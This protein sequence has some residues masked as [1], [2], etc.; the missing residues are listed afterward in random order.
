M[1]GTTTTAAIHAD[2]TSQGSFRSTTFCFLKDFLNLMNENAINCG[3]TNQPL[4]ILDMIVDYMDN[5]TLLALTVTCHRFY[6][7][8]K[9]NHL[10]FRFMRCDIHRIHL[11]K[12]L[13]DLPLY[14][15]RIR[16]IELMPEAEDPLLGIDSVVE[17]IEIDAD[18]EEVVV[19]PYAM[20]G[21]PERTAKA[22]S[23]L[24]SLIR[25][26][27]RL[28]SFLDR[29]DISL[30]VVYSA[31]KE[32]RPNL[33]E[34]HLCWL[35]LNQPPQ[36]TASLRYL[37]NLTSFSINSQFSDSSLDALRDLLI[38]NCPLLQDIYIHPNCDCGGFRFNIL[39]LFQQGNWHHL[40]RLNIG[41]NI[42][43]WDFDVGYD[44]ETDELITIVSDFLRRHPMLECLWFWRNNM[45]RP[46]CIPPDAVP[47][48]RR[49]MFNG[50][51]DHT[52]LSNVVP[53]EVA[54]HLEFIWTDIK[55]EDSMSH[56]ARMAGLKSC[57]VD[58]YDPTTIASLARAAPQLEHLAIHR[59]YD[60]FF[61][62]GV[63]QYN[64]P[65]YLMR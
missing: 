21:T 13:Q 12:T 43:L 5:S 35:G 2:S 8:L 23:A 1:C 37:Q 45:L 19:W 60:R 15:S 25:G 55:A 57:V 28:E 51:S 56:I 10:E 58:A 52:Q 61:E 20:Q 59:E 65:I 53:I 26:M 6:D 42:S 18:D 44:L 62:A 33:K 47:K 54:E 4:E 3:I 14:A 24:A 46:R 32:S 9:P 49:L 16:R 38:D 7:H 27:H 36:P 31:L 34:V 11:W 29:T 41:R 48:L 39:W 50:T 64:K 30:E 63:S 17:M 22:S 40:R